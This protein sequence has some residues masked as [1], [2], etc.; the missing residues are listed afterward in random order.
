MSQ[1]RVTESMSMTVADP[2]P[3][4][5][6]FGRALFH[7]LGLAVLSVG[8]AI[9]VCL[10]SLVGTLAVL[11]AHTAALAATSRL[12]AFRRCVDEAAALED[13]QR[14]AHD[15]EDRML[16]AAAE[17]RDQYSELSARVDEVERHDG[18]RLSGR[19]ELQDLLDYYCDL[20]VGHRRC[21]EVLAL[22]DRC[23]LSNQLDELTRRGVQNPRRRQRAEI[24]ARRIQ[25]WDEC[26]ARAEALS[27]NLAVV[28]ELIR[29]VG[30]RAACPLFDGELEREIENRLADLDE[31]ETA[32]K[33]LS[34]AA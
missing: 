21:L 2:R 33:E 12:S 18:G 27:E 22:A 32:L 24:I 9:G 30:Q 11:A 8:V 20:S 10:G 16:H 3:G 13:R 26:K 4:Y 34:A 25:H 6:Y 5:A 29:L 7:P 14:R 19:L 23:H 1:P 31:Q 17:H 15:R 28:A